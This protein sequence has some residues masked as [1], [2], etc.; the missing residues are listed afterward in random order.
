[1]PE[2]WRR[3]TYDEDWMA[4]N[5]DGKSFLRLIKRNTTDSLGVKLR[6]PIQ[7]AWTSLEVSLRARLTDFE[8]GPEK[9]HGALIW[10]GFTN[11]EGQQIGNF[12]NASL[13]IQGNTEDWTELRKVVLVPSGA[14]EMTVQI[15]LA[16]SAGTFDVDD[17]EV[18]PFD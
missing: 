13:G 3:K 5:E 18:V 2:E 12:P 11:A 16:R 4:E 6:V 15:I 10:F 8:H 1:M 9:W 7:Q 14:A 17:M